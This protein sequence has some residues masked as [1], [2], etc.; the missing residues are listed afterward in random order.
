MLF[1][2]AHGKR[3]LSFLLNFIRHFFRFFIFSLFV[4]F[5]YFP[6]MQDWMLKTPLLWTP[7]VLNVLL[8]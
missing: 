6:I 3:T 5:R 8:R 4:T 7:G 2:N 1:T